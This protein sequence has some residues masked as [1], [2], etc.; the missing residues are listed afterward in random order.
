[1]KIKK[2][3]VRNISAALKLER[4]LGTQQPRGSPSSISDSAHELRAHG[5][6]HGTARRN[7]RNDG[8]RVRRSR[9]IRIPWVGF[10]NLLHELIRALHLFDEVLGHRVETQRATLRAR[11][12]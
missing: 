12:S 1:M 9:G 10:C 5:D 6:R 11:G 7:L 8:P 4:R 3:N 2:C